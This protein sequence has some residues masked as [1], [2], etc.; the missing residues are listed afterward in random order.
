MGTT[1][2]DQ[3]RSLQRALALP[4]GSPDARVKA[5]V[6]AASTAQRREDFASA[7]ARAEAALELAQVHQDALGIANAYS[8]LG[9]LA[10]NAGDAEGARPHLLAALA[11]F[12]ALGARGRVASTLCDLA[13]LDSR[14]AVDEGGD[15]AALARALACYE[16]A[17]ALYRA[18]GQTRSIARALHGVAYLAYKQRDLPRA[19]DS[20]H[21]LLAQE[22]QDGWR[23]MDYL[24]DIADIAG[25][26]G[27]PEVAA[28]LYGAA[29]AQR[30]R[31]QQPVGA[32]Y[33][34][35]FAR[36]VA[37]SR[38]T[39]GENAF[40]AG[41]A[42]GRALPLDQAVAEALALTTDNTRQTPANEVRPSPE[43]HGL[44]AREVEV[45]RLLAAGHSNRAI[46]DALFISLPTVKV[47]IGHIFAKLGLES[48]AAAVAY[49][50]R[51]GL[52]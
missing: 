22:W 25:R 14:D 31:V 47:H 21:E 12:R 9:L 29:D 15:P 52:V 32:L 13:T 33:Q 36:E 34:A 4:G 26:I 45:L 10:L 6:S 27:R 28:R 49:A 7:R 43:L 44:T 11:G 42:D 23:V 20:I 8:C 40:A 17:L 24:E 38:R 2:R 51:Q 37:I 41:W 50:H 48:R 19:L 18:L 46:A 39:L 1:V 16:E 30:E 3:E 5:L 35:E